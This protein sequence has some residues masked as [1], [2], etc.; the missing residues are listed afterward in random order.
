MNAVTPA[1]LLKALDGLMLRAEVTA[2]NV[3]N[4]QSPGY[5][6]LAVNFE[7]ALRAA[8]TKDSAHVARVAPRIVPAFDSAGRPEMRLD[9][10]LATA[11][12]TA[13]R[14]AALTELLNRRLQL[15]AL[16][17]SGTR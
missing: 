4:A 1:L 11:S 9:L 6:P 8:A 12:A 5:R 15:E 17:V 16:A 10:E 2:Q 3:A 14:Y 13:G 7:A